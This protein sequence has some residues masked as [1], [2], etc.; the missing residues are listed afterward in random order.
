MS[1]VTQLQHL[2]KVVTLPN[3]SQ[4][5]L[6]WVRRLFPDKNIYQ[7]SLKSLK[8]GESFTLWYAEITDGKFNL[9]SCSMYKGPVTLAI[10]FALE[11]YE[12]SIQEASKINH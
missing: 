5:H 12:N 4:W 3:G 6:I 2:K 11:E 8:Y 1:N 9:L 7:L 10:D